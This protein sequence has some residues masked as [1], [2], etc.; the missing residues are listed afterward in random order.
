MLFLFLFLFEGFA[1]VDH[2]VGEFLVDGV[3]VAVGVAD[4]VVV[5]VRFECFEVF[6]AQAVAQ[7]V[8]FLLHGVSGVYVGVVVVVEVGVHDVEGT[9]HEGAHLVEVGVEGVAEVGGVG[10]LAL[11]AEG[12]PAT[13]NPG[14]LGNNSLIP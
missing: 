1:D 12:S 13:R 5:A 2:V 4:V 7:V 11:A 14:N 9:L 3:E 6:V 8:D 10:A